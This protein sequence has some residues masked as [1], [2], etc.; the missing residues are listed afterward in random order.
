MLVTPCPPLP[1]IRYSYAEVLF[2][3]PPTETV[4]KN[5]SFAASSSNRC[6]EISPAISVS[7]SDSSA[8]PLNAL[9]AFRYASRSSGS[10]SI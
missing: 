9:D 2:P 7:C 10:I 1:V 3:N 5:S 4:S 6:C 8:S